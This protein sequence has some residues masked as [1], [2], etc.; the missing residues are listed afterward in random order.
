M[1]VFC[2]PVK[3]NNL[4]NALPAHAN[5]NSHKQSKFAFSKAVLENLNAEDEKENFV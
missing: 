5:E 3:N 2:S 1:G 4:F